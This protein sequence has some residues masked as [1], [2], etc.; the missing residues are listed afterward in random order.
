MPVYE[1]KALNKKGKQITGMLDAGD[2]KTAKNQLRASQIFPVSLKEVDTEPGMNAKNRLA[3][4]APRINASEI[5]VMTRQLATLVS[6]GF[7][8]ISALNTIQSQI[9]KQSFKR[10]VSKIK[11]SIQ[12]GAGFAEA[13][14]RYPGIFSGIYI[15][16]VRAGEASGTLGVVLDRLADI[17]EKQNKMNRKIQAAMAYPILMTLIGIGV[18]CFLLTVIVP[19]ITSIFEEMNQSLPLSTQTLINISDILRQWW[20]LLA[21]FVIFISFLSRLLLKRPA[22]RFAVDRLT[23]KTPVIGSLKQKIDVARF[24]RTLGSLLEN[25]V[26]LLDALTIVQKITGNKVIEEAIR[27]AG[28]EVEKGRELGEVLEKNV[29]FPYLAIQM[30]KVG[31]QT[32]RLEEML[33]KVARVYDEEIETSVVG[34]TS[35]LEPIIILIMA[36]VVGFIVLSI[37]LPIFEMNQL[38]S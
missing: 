9:T 34:L 31:E 8:L 26:I 11:D 28:I 29:Y 22:I 37:C 24:S 17:S 27:Q 14:S 7:P 15:N 38:V 6:A 13:L 23:L 16:M 3:F 25:G 2:L 36:V 1:Y 4:L 33:K 10:V 21:G 5:A 18:L 35:L 19:N 30:I 20:W 12:E 32:G